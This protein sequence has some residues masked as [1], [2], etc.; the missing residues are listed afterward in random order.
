MQRLL[1]DLEAQ[2]IANQLEIVIVDSASPEDERKIV[3]EF[4]RSYDNIVYLRTDERENSHVALNP[5]HSDGARPIPDLANADD[6]HRRDAFEQMAAVL[7]S[8]PG[9]ALVYADSAITEQENETL[10]SAR[11][12][13]YLRLPQFDHRRLFR[14]CCVGPQPMWRRELH[15]KYGFF[16]PEFEICGDYEF[17]LRTGVRETFHHIPE[18]LGL[19]F[20]SPTSN[21]RVNR[22]QRHQ[23]TERADG[24][25]G[26][27]SGA[28]S[29]RGTRTIM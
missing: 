10:E 22:I 25:T 12:I 13:G 16:D 24:G 7:E 6:R 19:Y 23:E 27:H 9:V 15:D 1:E 17:W 14:G 4:R 20:M 21:E 5:R 29:R 28:N 8:Q 18:V 2:T 3:E 26:R 11:S